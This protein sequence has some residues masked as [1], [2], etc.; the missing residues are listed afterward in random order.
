MIART[1]H[2]R[3]TPGREADYET[4]AATQSMPMFSRLPGCRDER[5]DQRIVI[6][7]IHPQ[8]EFGLGKR[9]RLL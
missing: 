3:L 1:W 6:V 8:V 9:Y 7:N 5:T 4:F 2:A